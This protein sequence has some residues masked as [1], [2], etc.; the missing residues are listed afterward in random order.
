MKKLCTALAYCMLLSGCVV[1][2]LNP[3]YTE[4][5]VVEQPQL[6]GSWYFTED[7]ES[8]DES[9][10]VL[11]KGKMIIYD[12][13]G[14]PAES[15]ITFFKI[16][17]VLFADIFPQEGQLKEDLVKDGKP[18]HLISRVRIISAERFSFN[19]LDYDWLAVEL[20]AGRI[21][22]PFEKVNSDAGNDII[23]TATSEQWVEFL[24]KYKDDLQA[25]PRDGEA[26]LERKMSSAK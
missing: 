18:V 25:F 19:A 8:N 24:R 4:D 6:E 20:E 10:L 17:D 26:P 11:S 16:D 23:F 9:P 15:K 12:D 1:G 7:I 2:S 3:F 22:L 14:Q 5:L 13:K 21:Q